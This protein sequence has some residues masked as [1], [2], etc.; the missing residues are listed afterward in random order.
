[1]GFV[2]SNRSVVA[3][4]AT[5]LSLLAGASTFRGPLPLLCERGSLLAAGVG[6]PLGGDGF[7]RH[8][9]LWYYRM[10]ASRQRQSP[11]RAS[12]RL[13]RQAAAGREC[14]DCRRWRNSGARAKRGARLL[15]EC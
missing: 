9:G 2:A 13:R 10:L 15:E 3:F 1:M 11:A 7:S 12:L 4:P 14:Q 8:A 5:P 6:A